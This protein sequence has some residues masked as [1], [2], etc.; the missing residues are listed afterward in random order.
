MRAFRPLSILFLSSAALLAQPTVSTVVNG[1]S[2]IL[3]GLPNSAIAQGAIFVVY[4]TGLGPASIV[5]AASFPLQTSLAGTSVRI[6]VGGTTVDAIMVYTLATQVAAILPSRTPV[7]SGTLTVTFNGQTSAGFTIAIVKSNIGLVALN[8][9]GT[10]DAVVT[11]TN[12]SVVLA[13]NAPN[14]GETVVFW[15]TGLGPVTYDETRAPLGG[16]MTD[17]PLEVFVGG[18]PATV[19]YRGRTG[20]C[21]GLDQINVTLPQGVTGCVVP[22]VMKIGN[23]VSNTVTLPIAASGRQCTPSNPAISQGDYERILTRG[24]YTAGGVTLYRQTTIVTTTVPGMPPTTTTTKTD[25]GAAAFVRVSGNLSSFFSSQIDTA[26]YGSCVVYF[27]SGQTYNP[28]S[29]ITFESLDAGNITINGPSGT[30]SL[31]KTNVGGTIGYSG[32][33]G[34]GT[35]GNYLDPGAYTATATGGPVIGAFTG[36]HT[37]PAELVWTN[38]AAI[39]SVDRA[40]GVTVNWQ[41]GDPS[42]FVTI[43]GSSYVITTGTNAVG[44]TFICTAKTSDGTFTVPPVVLLSLPASGSISAGGFSIPLPGGLSVTGSASFSKIDASNLDFGYIYSQVGTFKTVT[45]Q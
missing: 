9:R 14:P 42:G 40:A 21:S 28:L 17:V 43:T 19:L 45:Y 31:S 30:R 11:L 38:Q 12:D 7:G 13:N 33:F 6:T 24:S 18:R 41:G 5:Q 32:T 25:G 1:A 20:C 8:S 10:G 27:Y 15:A 26:T 3:P 2:N 39:T 16:D 44:A 22:V 37:I 29:G 4:G 35:P 34:N 23:L 36:R